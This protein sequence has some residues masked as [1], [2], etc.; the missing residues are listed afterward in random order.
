MGLHTLSDTGPLEHVIERQNSGLEGAVSMSQ[1]RIRTLDDIPQEILDKLP[2]KA[3]NPYRIRTHFSQLKKMKSGKIET[4]GRREKHS[5]ADLI[6]HYIE[7]EARARILTKGKV[8][9]LLDSQKLL[10]ARNGEKARRLDKQDRNR[11]RKLHSNGKLEVNFWK[12]V[13]LIHRPGAPHP[14][15]YEFERAVEERMIALRS[16]AKKELFFLTSM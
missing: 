9:I 11:L 14:K 8:L 16:T 2:K 5:E 10:L 12:H 15:W 3:R 7:I 4:R 6:R 1:F 13:R